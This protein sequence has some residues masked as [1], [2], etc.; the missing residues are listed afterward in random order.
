MQDTN[1]RVLIAEPHSNPALVQQITERAGARA[2]TLVPSGTDYIT[3]F[4]ENVKRLSAFL[5]SG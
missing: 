1:V 3:L 2:V 4:E 5:G